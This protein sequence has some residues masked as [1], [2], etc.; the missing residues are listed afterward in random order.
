[1]AMQYNWR[2]N[3][4]GK[5][6]L[7]HMENEEAGEKVFDATLSLSAR[8]LHARS[9]NRLLLRYPFLSAKVGLAIYWQALKL[10]FKRIPV[11]AHPPSRV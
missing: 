10:F 6:L 1:M 3:T 8:P 2:S 11:H 4:P 9:L 7:L 5:R